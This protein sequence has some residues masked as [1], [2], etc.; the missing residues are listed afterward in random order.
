MVCW[1]PGRWAAGRVA[2]RRN[3]AERSSAGAAEASRGVSYPLR[4]R[5][6]LKYG[7]LSSAGTW[8]PLC[9]AGNHVP[10]PPCTAFLTDHHTLKLATFVDHTEAR[11]F[12]VSVTANGD[13]GG[14][15]SSPRTTATALATAGP[16]ED[17]AARLP[18]GPDAA[19]ATRGDR[20][21][22]RRPS[23]RPSPCVRVPA[24]SPANLGDT[25]PGVRA[26]ILFSS[27]RLTWSVATPACMPAGWDLI[28]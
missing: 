5:Q 3:D 21:P 18:G 10:P 7:S 22:P 14:T 8:P 24:V 20:H 16:A 28:G 17:T 12:P 15:A 11:N 9:R 23:L 26:A 25:G 27:S 4:S 13:D 6:G 19:D 1:T 2:L